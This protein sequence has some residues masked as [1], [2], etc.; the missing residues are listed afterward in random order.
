M[1]YQKKKVHFNFNISYCMYTHTL[2][3]KSFNRFG[4]WLK[5]PLKKCWILPVW[6]IYCIYSHFRS[7]NSRFV[8]T[9]WRL[10]WNIK[11]NEVRWLIWSRYP[12]FMWLYSCGMILLIIQKNTEAESEWKVRKIVVETS[13]KMSLSLFKFK[14]GKLT[15]KVHHCWWWL[16]CHIRNFNGCWLCRCFSC[17]SSC[18]CRCSNRCC[19]RLSCC[20]WCSWSCLDCCCC[21]WTWFCRSDNWILIWILHQF[22]LH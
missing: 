1:K 18:C 3:I 10:Q 5:K 21:C 13:F 6:L 15:R 16:L 2:T 14:S 11:V 17:C 19:C 22:I 8:I 12:W 20:S 4:L 7:L 9:L